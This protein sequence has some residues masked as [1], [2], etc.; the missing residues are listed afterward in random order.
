[1]AM[2]GTGQ[3]ATLSSHESADG[4]C[5]ARALAKLVQGGILEPVSSGHGLRDGRGGG[6]A[7]AAL[8]W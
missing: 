3:W 1:M 4:H 5:A 8:L 7:G 2:P 6:G